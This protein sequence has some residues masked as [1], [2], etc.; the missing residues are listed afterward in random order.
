VRRFRGGRSNHAPTGTTWG[1]KENG[2]KEFKTEIPQGALEKEITVDSAN[3]ADL[4]RKRLEREEEGEKEAKV[5]TRCEAVD[6]R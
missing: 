4:T 6:L 1:E 2:W 5:R 3:P